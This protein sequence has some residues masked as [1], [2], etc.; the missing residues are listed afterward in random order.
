[1]PHGIVER[2]EVPLREVHDVD[3][4]AHARAVWRRVVVAEDLGAIVGR[5]LPV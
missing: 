5:R 4:V 2:G 1:V 3:I